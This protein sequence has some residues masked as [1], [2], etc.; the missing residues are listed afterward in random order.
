[1]GTTADKIAKAIRGSARSGVID[2]SSYRAAKAVVEDAG[3]GDDRLRELLAKGYDPAH[4]AFVYAQNF[5]SFVAEEL[6]GL[7]EFRQFST[8]VGKAE[9]DYLPGYPPQSPVT[10]SHFTMWAFFD[11]Q[12]GQSHE[13]MGTCLLRLAG[14]M[15]FPVMLVDALAAM[16]KSRMGFYVHEGFED[17]FVRL[18]EIGGEGV[19]IFHPA[20][21]FKGAKGQIWFGRLLAPMN[22]LI[23]Y[24]V[25][26]TTPYVMVETTE[27]MIAAYLKR[28]IA[29]L[30]GKR[31]S[32]GMDAR[33]F[34]LKHG[35]SPNHWNEYIFC[36]YSNHRNDAVFLAGV[37]D[38]SESL[39][40]GDLMRAPRR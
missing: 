11:V 26:F 24:H 39:P 4:A 14:D 16:Q 23:K 1:M 21:G 36:A 9:D 29:R 33:E 25:F 19:K 5:A 20:A 13:T 30:G 3:L 34:V 17:R 8:I 22:D 27:A 37:P 35:P 7:K 32:P 15:A 40:H 31:L 10:V 6:S 2:L 12:F 28:E 18:R 38:D